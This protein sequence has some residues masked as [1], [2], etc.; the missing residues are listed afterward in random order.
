MI[1][2]SPFVFEDFVAAIR[3]PEQSVLIGDIHIA[4]LK[5]ILRD[6]DENQTQYAVTE[7]SVSFQLVCQLMDPVTYAE[8]LRQYIDSDPRFPK[9]ILD[10]VSSNY[11]FVSVEDRIKVLLWLCDQFFETS[12]FLKAIKSDG[13]IQVVY[14]EMN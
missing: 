8:V 1:Q 10:V 12:A 11:P 2:I 4:L 9:D 7:T 3:S 5:C 14:N 6:D 13:K